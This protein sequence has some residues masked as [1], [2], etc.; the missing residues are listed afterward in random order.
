MTMVRKQLKQ[1]HIQQGSARAYIYLKDRN[2]EPQHCLVV[3]LGLRLTLSLS[4]YGI[5]LVNQ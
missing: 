3:V 5:S 1:T 2:C 4:Y